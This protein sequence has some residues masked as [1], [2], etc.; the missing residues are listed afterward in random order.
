MLRTKESQTRGRVLNLYWRGGEYQI[1]HILYKNKITPCGVG[2]KSEF[3]RNVTDTL[4]RERT[5]LELPGG[6]LEGWNSR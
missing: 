6:R 5:D 1:L 3:G 2:F 4:A